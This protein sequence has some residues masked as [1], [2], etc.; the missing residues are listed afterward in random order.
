MVRHAPVALSRNRT[1]PDEASA[2]TVPS[3]FA[4]VVVDSVRSDDASTRLPDDRAAVFADGRSTASAGEGLLSTTEYR[5]GRATP[6]P[7]APRATPLSTASKAAVASA[8]RFT[9]RRD[10]HL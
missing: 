4:H 8:D 6:C 7:V 9:V 2:V 1:G 5:D 3:G 10:S